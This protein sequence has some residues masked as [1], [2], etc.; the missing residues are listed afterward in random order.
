VQCKYIMVIMQNKLLI[1][2]P[3]LSRKVL[4]LNP[5]HI[6]SNRSR[7]SNTSWGSQSV[8]Q[9]QAKSPMQARSE[10][11]GG[12]PDHLWITTFSTEA[13]P[14]SS[15]LNSEAT[16]AILCPRAGEQLT[17]VGRPEMTTTRT[18]GTQHTSPTN[19]K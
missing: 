18:L 9:I 7:I 2:S 19:P 12:S 11:Q 4:A 16:V 17:S 5:I 14:N 13:V 3:S 8:V 15:S 6:S 10:I 1:I